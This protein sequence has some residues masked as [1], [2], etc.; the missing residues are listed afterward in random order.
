WKSFENSEDLIRLMS[1]DVPSSL[2]SVQALTARKRPTPSI[3]LM[4]SP[5]DTDN[6]VH[7][8]SALSRSAF[9]INVFDV[10]ETPR[11]SAQD[12][13]RHVTSSYGTV[14]H[15]IDPAR[16]GASIHNARC[17]FVSG[18]AMAA[19]KPVLMIQDG[20]FDQPVDYRDVALS[21]T[22]AFQIR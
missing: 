19:E 8:G 5:Y 1:S 10:R 7:L 21:C 18:L 17:A 6:S 4:K 14:A 3:F 16:R 20:T 9:Q 15:L 13:I 12:A 2:V 11:L 22:D